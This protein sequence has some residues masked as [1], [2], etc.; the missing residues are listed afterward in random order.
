M[1]ENFRS[2]LL[3]RGI[4]VERYQAA[5]IGEQ[6]LILATYEQQQASSAQGKCIVKKTQQ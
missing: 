5:T 3:S 2:Y 6:G 4:N 1:N